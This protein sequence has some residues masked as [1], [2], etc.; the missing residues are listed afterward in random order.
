[1]VTASETRG[2]L[3]ADFIL[4]PHPDSRDGSP[5]ERWE[6]R[7]RSDP[8][9]VVG[10]VG[11]I[12]SGTEPFCAVCRRTRITAEGRVRSCQ[13]SHQETGLRELLRNGSSDDVIAGLW[14]EA[15]WSK[16]KTHGKVERVSTRR[17]SS[18][19]HAPRAP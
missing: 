2:L 9:R 16:P 14:S 7:R 13:F 5:A 12:A 17:I 11:I 8:H 4:T 6:V 10:T 1:M 15:M 18:S 3:E 19:R